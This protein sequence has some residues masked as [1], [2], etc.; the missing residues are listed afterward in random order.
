MSKR[1]G[2]EKVRFTHSHLTDVAYEAHS[3][4]LLQV[5]NGPVTSPTMSRSETMKVYRSSR[6]AWTL[7][8]TVVR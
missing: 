4:H 1:E 7:D 2:G 6:T 5:W 8:G 3:S